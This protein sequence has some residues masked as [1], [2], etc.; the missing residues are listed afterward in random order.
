MAT[1]K[2]L[3]QVRKPRLQA[4]SVSN[5]RVSKRKHH[6]YVRG[7]RRKDGLLNTFVAARSE[8]MRIAERNSIESPLLRLPGEIRDKI[9]RYA[10]GEHEISIQNLSREEV[11]S[12]G[13][14]IRT[15]HSEA[16]VSP[17]FVRHTFQLPKVCRQVYVESSH[18]VYLLNTFTFLSMGA[19][20]RWIK[21]RCF[22]Q[23]RLIAS[24]DIPRVYTRLYR[25][26]FRR[27]FRQKFPN[28]RRIGIDNWTLFC[29]YGEIKR[30]PENRQKSAFERW[31]DARAKIIAEVKEKEGHHVTVAWHSKSY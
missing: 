28:I 9:W 17:G 27:S 6:K 30:V 21:N 2:S 5:G 22:G 20:D 11:V 12:D 10:L 13:Y 31:N 7:L 4:S 26:G 8:L 23:R 3:D 1:Q 24:L 16:L 19:F 14:E 25:S 18:H 29:E 15:L